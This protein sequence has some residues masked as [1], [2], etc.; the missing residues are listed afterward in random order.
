[1]RASLGDPVPHLF[2]FAPPDAY[3]ETID[4]QLCVTRWQ[5]I[6]LVRYNLHDSARLISWRALREVALNAAESPFRVVVEGAGDGL[7]DLI[8]IAGRADRCLILCG[9]NITEAMLDEAV[10]SC[11]AAGL[12][13]RYRASIVYEDQRQRLRLELETSGSPAE[14][15]YPRLVQ[16]LG[17]VQP[18]FRDDW[19]SVYRVWDD[20]PARRVLRLEFIPWPGLAQSTAIKSRGIVP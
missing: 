18:E 2:H 19:S 15:P 6:P 14:D 1:L 9:T 13:G 4:G 5:G 10:A 11:A 16:A 20:D 8:A 12:T 3:L 7:P 17:R